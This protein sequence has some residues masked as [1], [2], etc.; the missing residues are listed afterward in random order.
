MK[1]LV[2]VLKIVI[3]LGLVWLV[4]RH[5]DLRAALALMQAHPLA[6][7]GTTLLFLLQSVLAAMRLP[8]VVAIYKEHASFWLSLRLWLIC[9]FASQT[10]VT[11]IAGDAMRV[12]LLNKAG[13]P[14]RLATRSILFDRMFGLV[15]LLLLVLPAGLLLVTQYP[16]PAAL[17]SSL[18]GLLVIAAGALGGFCLSPVLLRLANALPEKI[19]DNRVMLPFRELL[20]IATDGF[21]APGPSAYVALIGVLMH[22][23]NPVIFY[24]LLNSF[25]ATIGLWPL[26]LVTFPVILIALLPISFAGWGVREGGMVA[27]LGLFGID[28]SLAASASVAFGLS[29]ILSSLPGGVLLLA[30]TW[31]RRSDA[32]DQASD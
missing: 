5:I 18:W 4:F 13:I 1:L 27:G 24:I 26:L 7:V 2:L 11:F 20:S 8:P 22:A 28:P 19:R 17:R 15:V 10:M 3:S 21:H 23:M 25:G 32:A 29:L 9:T 31:G 12:W 14:L 16:M 30:R 6:I